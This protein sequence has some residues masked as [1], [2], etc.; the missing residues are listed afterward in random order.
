MARGPSS[1][2]MG[3][4][5]ADGVNPLAGASRVE[6]ELCVRGSSARLLGGD[7]DSLCSSGH[8]GR[9]ARRVV[10]LCVARAVRRR[11]VRATCGRPRGRSLPVPRGSQVGLATPPGRGSTVGSCS[12]HLLS[13]RPPPC[14]TCRL[15]GASASFRSWARTAGH[16]HGDVLVGEQPSSAPDTKGVG[17]DSGPGPGAPRRTAGGGSARGSA[18]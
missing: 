14:A 4:L 13:V 9:E 15:H 11:E 1:A 5:A 10:P 12:H 17:P 8:C 16:D 6:A 2:S 18:R 7:A 3:A